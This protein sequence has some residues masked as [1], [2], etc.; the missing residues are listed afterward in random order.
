[1]SVNP[2]DIEAR[3]GKRTVNRPFLQLVQKADPKFNEDRRKQPEYEWSNGRKFTG[4]PSQRG[5]YAD[6]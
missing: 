1:M 5:A 4:N 3:K 6:S 2:S